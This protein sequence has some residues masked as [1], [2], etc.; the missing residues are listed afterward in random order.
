MARWKVAKGGMFFQPALFYFVL[1]K[2]RE[3]KTTTVKP[4]TG[5][6]ENGREK[7]VRK[8][9]GERGNSY[10]QETTTQRAVRMRHQERLRRIS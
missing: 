8:N 7:Y 5:A 9:Y 2:G 10:Y 6:N 1:P 4:L 3:G